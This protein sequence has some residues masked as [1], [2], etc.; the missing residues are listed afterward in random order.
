MKSAC[1]LASMT[2]AIRMKKQTKIIFK[3]KSFSNKFSE[4]SSKNTPNSKS[5][6]C[7]IFTTL[8]TKW[9]TS[10]SFSLSKSYS[11]METTN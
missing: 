5:Y 10:G 3:F 8:G 11:F 1:V 2:S 4:I 6:K 9:K 7:S